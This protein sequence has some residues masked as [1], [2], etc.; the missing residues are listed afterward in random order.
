MNE[1]VGRLG[2]FVGRCDARIE[3][4]KPD[5]PFNDLRHQGVHRAAAGG[6]IV[7]HIGTLG[8]LLEG[9]IDCFHLPSD[10]TDAIE[11]LLFLF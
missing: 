10:S 1:I 8:L 3:N 4:V 5:V 7:K 9:A 6:N 2:L 11:Q